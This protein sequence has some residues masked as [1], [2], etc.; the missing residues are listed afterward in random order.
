LSIGAIRG[1]RCKISG[2]GTALIASLAFLP[3]LLDEIVESF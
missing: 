3:M 2:C 1:H